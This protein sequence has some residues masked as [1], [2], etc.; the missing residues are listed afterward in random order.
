MR[1][2]F[3][4]HDVE[5]LAT[6]LA[7][8]W[9]YRGTFVHVAGKFP[10]AVVKTSGEGRHT[11]SKLTGYLHKQGDVYSVGSRWIARRC[12]WSKPYRFNQSNIIG[13]ANPWPMLVDVARKMLETGKMG[14]TSAQ[15]RAV[16]DEILGRKR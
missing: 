14:R 8:E 7:G 6:M 10:K 12:T 3:S 9:P 11:R 15:T 5:E 2:K 13:P 4:Q 16:F 1:A